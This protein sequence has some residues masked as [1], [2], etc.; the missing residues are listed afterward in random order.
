M[1][2]IRICRLIYFS[3]KPLFCFFF[4]FFVYSYL[5]SKP[6]EQRQMLNIGQHALPKITFG[7]PG[8][9]FVRFIERVWLQ[10]LE[11]LASNHPSI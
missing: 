6:V 8:I 2:N 1:H 4:S 3:M 10:I 11:Q 5:S 9:T 7:D